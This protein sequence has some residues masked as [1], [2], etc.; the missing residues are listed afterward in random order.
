MSKTQG[1]SLK[2][3][4]DRMEIQDILV[5]Y[6]TAVDG[7]DFPLLDSCFSEDAFLDYSVMNGPAGDFPTIRAWLEVSLCH[8]EAM[9]HSI[10]NTVYNI[11]GD[12]ATARTQFRNPNTM[13]Y[14]DGSL[15]LFTVGGY[16]EDELVCTAAGWKIKRRVERFTY[17]DGALPPRE[18]IPMDQ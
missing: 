14:P 5:R 18:T 7:C 2:E 13:R 8:L 4:S 12:R 1:I 11:D 9:Q 17:L 3:I 15:H 6:C 10:S 16:Y